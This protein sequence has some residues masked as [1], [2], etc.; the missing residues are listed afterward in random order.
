[1]TADEA[2]YSDDVMASDCYVLILLSLFA[3]LVASSL[4]L[5]ETCHFSTRF[6]QSYFTSYSTLRAELNAAIITYSV[7]A[8]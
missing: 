8:G 3:C 1:V 4:S 7:A 6:V 5:F 2:S